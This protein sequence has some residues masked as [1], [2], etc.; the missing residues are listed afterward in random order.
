MQEHSDRPRT[1]I[2]PLRHPM[3]ERDWALFGKEEKALLGSKPVLRPSRAREEARP[4]WRKTSTEPQRLQ[5]VLS[6][7]GRCHGLGWDKGQ[8]ATS[9][10]SGVVLPSGSNHQRHNHPWSLKNAPPGLHPRLHWTG[11]TRQLR[12]P[13]GFKGGTFRKPAAA[14]LPATG[15][16]G[17]PDSPTIS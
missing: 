11:A 1:R 4:T 6:S 16:P 8:G 3:G 10:G 17:G 12:S 13:R 14:V 9:A 2:Y 15:T 7:L 5:K